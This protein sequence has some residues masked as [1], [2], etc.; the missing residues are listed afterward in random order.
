MERHRGGGYA[1]PQPV[2]VVGGIRAHNRKGDF[3]RSWWGKRWLAALDAFD[4][5]VRLGRGKNYARRGQVVSLEVAPGRVRARVQGT[6][7]KPY[8][9]EIRVR[10]FTPEERDLLGAQLGEEP[11]NAARLLGGEMP[12]GMEGLC[13]SLGLSLFPEG[14]KDLEFSCTCPDPVTPCKHLAAVFLLLAE[15]FDGDPLLLLRLRGLDLEALRESLLRE[16]REER[17]PVPQPLPPDPGAFWGTPELLPPPSLR[18]GGEVHA[19]WAR[20]LGN[21]PFWRSFRPFL[22]SLET[23]SAALAEEARRR[24]EALSGEGKG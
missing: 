3:A 17:L 5:G 13:R 10:P 11:R 18:P 15:A 7:A 8:E 16:A 23:L 2:R 21:L 20:R 14:R 12:Q 19:P 4:L 24:G 9:A 1:I 22:P 6:R